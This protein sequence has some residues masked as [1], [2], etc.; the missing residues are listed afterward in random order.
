[1]ADNST[2]EPWRDSAPAPH[3]SPNPG[4]VVLTAENIMLVPIQP[5]DHQFLYWLANSEEIAYRWRFRGVV[6]PF[7]SFVQQLNQGVFAQF[8]VRT[9]RDNEPIGHVVAYSADLRNGHTYVGNITTPRTIGTRLGAEAQLTFI[10][11]LFDLWNFQKIYV[12]VPEF[13]FAQI[14]TW[15][16]DDFFTLEGRL[17]GHIYYKNRFWDQYILALYKSTWAD[18]ATRTPRTSRLDD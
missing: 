11:Y 4:P 3:E 6:L 9:R 15:I 13:T 14:Q 1:M 8:V 17:R 2:S 18:R 5:S 7:E 12:E 16:G 10:H